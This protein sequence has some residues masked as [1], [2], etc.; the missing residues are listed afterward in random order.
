MK[1]GSTKE[2]ISS[3]TYVTIVAF[4]YNCLY[5]LCLCIYSKKNI[6]RFIYAISSGGYTPKEVHSEGL[7]V[8]L[9]GYRGWLQTKIIGGD[10]M[11]K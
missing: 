11:P 7:S 1:I 9:G 2:F 10:E 5:R 3:V 8:F 4:N 6:P